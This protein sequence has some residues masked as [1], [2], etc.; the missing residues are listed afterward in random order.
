ME[1]I[2]VL[3]VLYFIVVAVIRASRGD[4]RLTKR[5]DMKC[6]KCGFIHRLNGRELRT[7]LNCPPTLWNSDMWKDPNFLQETKFRHCNKCSSNF[8]LE[9]YSVNPQPRKEEG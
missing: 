7:I 2:A 4:P 3:I 6:N 8:K 1:G 9:E 5:Y